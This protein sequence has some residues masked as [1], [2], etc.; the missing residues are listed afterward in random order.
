M[1]DDVKTFSELAGYSSITSQPK[2]V[3]ITTLL[4]DRIVGGGGGGR[5]RRSIE[6]KEGG[7]LFTKAVIA[8]EADP[9]K[10]HGKWFY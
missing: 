9:S 3:R 8:D 7:K 2:N 10:R 5:R 1:H 4:A 6:E